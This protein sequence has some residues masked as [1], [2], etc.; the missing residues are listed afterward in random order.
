MAMGPIPT[1]KIHEEAAR[2]GMDEDAAEDFVVIIRTLDEVYLSWQAEEQET[3][4]KKGSDKP[5]DPPP[6]TGRPRRNAS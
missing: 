2:Q 4:R 1:S 5:Q 6:A 3:L